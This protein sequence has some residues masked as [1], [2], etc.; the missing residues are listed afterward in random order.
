M[1]T[2]QSWNNRSG[3][4][5]LREK[6]AKINNMKRT[7]AELSTLEIHRRQVLWQIWLPVTIFVLAFIALA[8][9]SAIGTSRNAD[10]GTFLSSISM[11]VLILPLIPVGLIAIIIL[12]ALIYGL[13]KVLQILPVYS[14][15][16]RTY[17]FQLSYFVL[18]W[19]N[20]LV[21]PVL[22]LQSTSAGLAKFFSLI[23]SR[24]SKLLNDPN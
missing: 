14:L 11:I 4:F 16:I 19:A 7:T 15:M 9:L 23:L 21:Q 3:T 10:N 2:C 18:T 6:H 24:K 20:R 22:W 13:A 5:Y 8:T 17:I 12:A 1:P